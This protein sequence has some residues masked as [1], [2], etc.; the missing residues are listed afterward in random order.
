MHIADQAAEAAEEFAPD[1]TVTGRISR[2]MRD[3]SLD[4]IRA[5][6]ETRMREHPMATILIGA[7]VG[8]LLGKT[9]SR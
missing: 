8:F 4:D 6:V 5:D 3:H 2:Y 1:H 9:L 7:G